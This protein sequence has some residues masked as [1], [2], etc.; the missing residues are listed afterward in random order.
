METLKMSDIQSFNAKDI[1]NKVDE[2]KK[3]LFDLKIQRVT[4][5]LEKSHEKNIIRK[6]IA[7]LLTQKTLINSNN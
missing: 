3:N 2:L 4:S 5:G 7:R 6:N 1:D